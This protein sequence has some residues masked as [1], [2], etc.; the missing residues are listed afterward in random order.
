[1]YR[2]SRNAIPLFVSMLALWALPGLGRALSQERQDAKPLVV[3]IY[4]DWCP[5][6]QSIKPVLAKINEEYK[7]R[8][9]FVRLDVTDSSTTAKSRELARSLGLE[10]FFEENKGTTSLVVIQSPAGHEIFRALH[11]NDFQHYARVLDRQLNSSKP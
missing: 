9:R 3:V 6:C 11:D 5:L 2:L 1:M 8:I 4:A 10:Q 7:G